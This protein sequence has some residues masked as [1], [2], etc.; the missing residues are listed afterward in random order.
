M[1]QKIE[2]IL[3]NQTGKGQEYYRITLERYQWRS[4]RLL[5]TGN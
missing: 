5:P 2:N 1:I 3:S 4:D